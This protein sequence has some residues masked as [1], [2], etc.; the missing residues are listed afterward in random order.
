MMKF[1]KWSS[2]NKAEKLGRKNAF[3]VSFVYAILIFIV[4]ILSFICIALTPNIGFAL[5]VQG[6]MEPFPL[7][8]IIFMQFVTPILCYIISKNYAI[9]C[10]YNTL[11]KNFSKSLAEKMFKSKTEKQC[12]LKMLFAYI[13]K[14]K[15]R[16]YKLR[17]L[18]VA[19]IY[20]VIDTEFV[21]NYDTRYQYKR[22]L[23]ENSDY[24]YYTDPLTKE[25]YRKK[26]CSVGNLFCSNLK[27]ISAYFDIPDDVLLRGDY[28]T[29]EEI[30]EYSKEI[31]VH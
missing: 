25:T 29:L 23:Y 18:Y 27:N 17:K 19:E 1:R 28:L 16:R 13:F 30:L 20:E 21:G 4:I 15:Y 3:K 26:P 22:I 9:N 31:K 14:R 5:A 24:S 2:L 11:S 8:A 12:K 10:A 6:F 7:I